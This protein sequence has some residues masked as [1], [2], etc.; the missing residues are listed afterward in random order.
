MCIVILTTETCNFKGVYLLSLE[1]QKV[2]LF[3]ITHA[4]CYDLF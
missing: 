2:L 3:K 4:Y 1:S